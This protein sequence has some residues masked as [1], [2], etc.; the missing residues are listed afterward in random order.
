V[1]RP[2]HGQVDCFGATA[3]ASGLTSGDCW[4]D[5]QRIT[6]CVITPLSV[7][8]PTGEPW[9]IFVKGPNKSMALLVNQ[10]RAQP[11]TMS[12]MK[13]RMGP[14]GIQLSDRTTGLNILLDEVRVPPTSWA[15]APRQVS[16]ALTNACDLAC[17]YCFAPKNPA[18]LNVKQVARWLSELD[19]NGCVGV[20]F[21]GGEP[22]LYRGFAELCHYTAKRT[23]LAVTF[24]THAHRLN[25]AIIASLSGS[26]HFVRVSM[27]GVG[28]T[29]EALRGRSFAVFQRRLVR[30]RGLAPFGINFVV[31]A[32][33]F[34]DLDAAC[35]LACELG[36]AEILLLPEQPTQ[37]SVGVDAT[38]TLALRKW[39]RF[40]RG[41][42][43]LTISEASSDGFPTCNPLARE[44]GLRGYAH[45]DARGVLK[46]FSYDPDGVVIQ[47]NGLMAALNVLRTN[48]GRD[49]Q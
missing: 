34:P 45:I 38:T 17:P 32:R 7:S 27:D 36:A 19:E 20:G 9:Q 49:K 10:N 12:Q 29:Y 33:T 22:T 16:I 47:E 5:P 3:A 28:E 25:D 23:R 4:A 30:L 40:Y 26:V 43:P 8:F 31:N 2:L 35:T 46:R 21:G 6:V 14:S 24:T 13:M 15:A 1:V 44:S 41:A 11:I 39:V 42:V 48:C 18:R 37:S